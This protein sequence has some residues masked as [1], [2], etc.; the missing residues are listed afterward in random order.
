MG[1]RHTI[2]PAQPGV[3]N[4][5]PFSGSL[6]VLQHLSWNIFNRICKDPEF[7]SR[8]IF[9]SSTKSVVFFK[10]TFQFFSCGPGFCFFG[11]HGYQYHHPEYRTEKCIPHFSSG[12]SRFLFSEKPE[13][14]GVF[15]KIHCYRV[16]IA[17]WIMDPDSGAQMATSRR[18]NYI[19]N[20]RN[21][22]YHPCF[23]SRFIG[24]L[25]SA[26]ASLHFLDKAPGNQNLE[27]DCYGV[28]PI[29]WIFTTF[30]IGN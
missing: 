12:A 1:K 16:F 17:W 4:M 27:R 6:G 19:W 20:L 25:H 5:Y 21:Y 7:P 14:L 30:G 15:R 24:N 10:R 18:N 8:H 22:T 3:W 9:L 26:S 13:F 28:V 2:F 11:N 23:W 29:V